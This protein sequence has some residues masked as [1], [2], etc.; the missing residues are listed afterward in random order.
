MSATAFYRAGAGNATLN[1]RSPDSRRGPAPPDGAILS[2]SGERH[3]EA[4]FCRRRK[5]QLIV[6]L[7]A[8]GLVARHNVQYGNHAKAIL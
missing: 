5:V 1:W 7:L 8:R 2:V 3:G 4:E 6:L